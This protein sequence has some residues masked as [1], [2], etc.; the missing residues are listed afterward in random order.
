MKVAFS[1][2]YERQF[3]KLAKANDRKRIAA[4]VQSIIDTKRLEDLPS[5][6]KLKGFTHAY[7]VRSGQFRIGIIKQPDGTVLIAAFDLRK[8]FYDVFP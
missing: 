1:K 2:K 5:I 7:R 6:K 3:D 4:A 8:D